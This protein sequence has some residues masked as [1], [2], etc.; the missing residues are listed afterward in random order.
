MFALLNPH[1]HAVFE[2]VVADDHNGVISLQLTIEQLRFRGVLQPNVN[3][4]RACMT[5]CDSVDDG[6]ASF[7]RQDRVARHDDRI[8]DGRP[9]QRASHVR[10]EDVMDAVRQRD[11]NRDQ[12]RRLI[13]VSRN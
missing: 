8:G 10:I 9:S 12:S 11:K 13:N 7:A 5:I 2:H 6:V 1:L 3:F 4:M